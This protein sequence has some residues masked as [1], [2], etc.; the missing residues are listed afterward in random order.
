MSVSQPG[1]SFPAAG[2]SGSS[3]RLPLHSAGD[4]NGNAF[5]VSSSSSSS[6]SSS[7]LGE[8]SPDSLRSLSSLSGGRTDS[9]LDYDM[10]EVTLT[11]TVITT[12]SKTADVNQV[13]R[14]ETQA[15]KLP[16]AELSES[17]DNSVSVYLDANSGDY[18][19]DTWYDNDNPT[20]ALSL[21][22]NSGSHGNSNG[23]LSSGSSVGRRR[24]SSTPD[25]DATEIPADDDD[26]DEGA[27]L[28]MS[29]DVAAR[30]TSMSSS[31]SSDV[32]SIPG[33]TGP[34]P[35]PLPDLC[36]GLGAKQSAGGGS[37]NVEREVT[38]AASV[39]DD[40]MACPMDLL[41]ESQEPDGVVNNEVIADKTEASEDLRE[42]TQISS[43]TSSSTNPVA[44][45]KE[46][47]NK[48]PQEVERSEVGLN[49]VLSKS[50]Q[51]S[52]AAK[53]KPVIANS[54]VTK[55]S[56]TKPSSLEAKKVCKQ[57]LKNVKP[58]VAS[59][60]TPSTPKTTSQTK[61]VPASGKRA[62]PRKE[63]VQAGDG[64]KRQ[65]SS[66]S[67]AKTAVLLKPI[68]GRN[69]NN[70]PS[71]LKPIQNTEAK[72]RGQSD[73]KRKKVV[74]NGALSSS[75]SSLGSEVA[76]E[77]SLGTP[78]KAAYQGP[79]LNGVGEGGAKDPGEDVTE[80]PVIDHRGGTK[81]GS[82]TEPSVEKPRNHGTW[83]MA[84]TMV[85]VRSSELGPLG[86]DAVTKRQLFLQKVSSKLGPNARQ[87]RKGARGDK[88]VLGAM[89]TPG[90]AP[91]PGQG[92]ASPGQGSPGPRQAQNDGSAL[93]KERPSAGGGSPTRPRPSQSQSQGIPKPRTAAERASG[94]PAPGSATSNPK[95]T[96][97]Q[98][99]ASGS[100]GRPAPPAVSKLPVKGL[101]TSLS[102]SSLGSSTSESNGATS[103]APVGTKPEECPSRSTLPVSS[104]SMTKPPSSSTASTTSTISNTTTSTI[105]NTTTTS[106]ATAA[107]KAP[108]M[109]SRALS[110]Q[111][112]TTATGL[113]APA[114]TAKTVAANQAAAKAAAAAA[115]G[116]APVKQQPQYP[117]QR[118]GSVR[119]TRP[120]T[121][122]TTVDKNKPR[123][124]PGRPTTANATSL[125][126]ASTGANNQN[127]NQ[128]PPDLVP[129]LVNANGPVTPVVPVPTASTTN[130]GSG[131]TGLGFR[132]RAGSRPGPRTPS[133]LQNG[134]KP[135]V[136]EAGSG[137]QTAA[138]GTVPV[139][140]NQS[141]E[142]AEK[143]NQGINQLRRLL[144]QGNKRVEALATVIQ[145]L[146]TEREE[147][148]KQKKELSGELANL[149]DELVS[150]SQCCER[151]QKEKEEVHINLE[152]AFKKLQ[153]QHKEELV[154]LE[155]RLRN[156]Y[157][158]EW[159]KVHQTYQ[160]EADKCRTLMEQQVEE[161]RSRQ[162]A[163]RKNQEVSHSQRM[164]LLKQQY[165]SSIQE[166]K[167][168]QQTDLENLGQ[169]LKETEV[170]LS[171]KIS[172]LSSEKEALNE[173][174]KAE[175][176]R[177]WRILSDKNL[178]D[179]HTVYLEQELES[180]KVVLEM[181]NNQLHQKEKKLMEM[182]KL[183]E[184][185]VK[186]EEC[187]KKVQ[188]ENE[189]Y[190][191]RMDK[192][193]ALSKQL[194]TE[195]VMLQQTLQKESKV[196]KRLSMENEELL[197]KLHNGDLLASPRRLSPTSP[198]HSP[199]NSA[200][201]PTA[202]T[203]SP[204]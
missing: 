130:T 1:E 71:N 147:A 188:Q 57:D 184:S 148:L 124:A 106:A 24:G 137:G 121:A 26:D 131:T 156:F 163:E 77:G 159:D 157:Q 145:H 32:L 14:G 127:Q 110:L 19:D 141:K 190:K 38:G 98:L 133:R 86:W 166:L 100:G 198:F 92:T 84:N 69:S 9:P 22:I 79:E 128:P 151:L 105:S 167:R 116:Q 46:M 164:E 48:S 165:D 35:D 160:E 119:L 3:M 64:G 191:A 41:A 185:N 81:E 7:C 31:Q 194:S 59:R 42:T 149:R 173:K 44:E 11:T 117:L 72:D 83:G 192:H 29:S 182:D 144:V 37:Q 138:H 16:T 51:P 30:T 87:Q 179:S 8:S 169:T 123:G 58:K 25:S 183:V 94:L 91:P 103:K 6:S 161:L 39:P 61:S 113:K 112:R 20:L 62:V 93:G 89:C 153:Q 181:K 108:A 177:R 49:P 122:S 40:K 146:F 175:E 56:A 195:Q 4:Q 23:D 126:P 170:S 196:N 111:G 85:S 95:A 74:V 45:V 201:F 199:R 129:D 18:C 139:K 99:P 155:D 73:Q 176:E 118:S 107:P 101:P 43:S 68:R 143:K 67:L 114:V 186:L 203:L 202:A 109:R 2:K 10:Y 189:D 125:G 178:K 80:E 158:T 78:R 162:E 75:I 102:S 134:S 120:N 82:K 66:A 180:L 34:D 197:W 15:G 152:E 54:A 168:N 28:S 150:T 204:R 171:E 65:R 88:G 36:M 76:E 50:N 70:N 12:T 200:S 172:E 27:F 52:R 132:P 13:V 96:A 55:T 17:N 154:Q 140:Q 47:E 97:N 53:T 21:T 193:A 5:P 63:D 174:L 115:V 104:Q 33:A 135:S 142:Q 136:A 60:S 90:A 187:L